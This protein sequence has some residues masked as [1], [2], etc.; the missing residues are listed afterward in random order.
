VSVQ[1]PKLTTALVACALGI[2]KNVLARTGQ[3]VQDVFTICDGS[4][5]DSPEEWRAWLASGN[6]TTVPGA[7]ADAVCTMG[8]TKLAALLRTNAKDEL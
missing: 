8:H 1:V 6:F 3:K 7:Y 4:A 5:R 2:T